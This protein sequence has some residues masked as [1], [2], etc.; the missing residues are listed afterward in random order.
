MSATSATRELDDIFDLTITV[1]GLEVRRIGALLREYVGPSEALLKRSFGEEALQGLSSAAAHRP[2]GSP[3]FLKRLAW[4]VILL[5]EY[6]QEI[7]A[8]RSLSEAQW[9]WVI[10]SERWPD[11]RRFMIRGGRERWLEL[12]HA[13]SRLS[14]RGDPRA[15]TTGGSSILKWLEEDLILAD[16]LRLHA[17]GFEKDAEGIFWLENM[18][19][20]AGL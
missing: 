15:S 3:R 8:S 5:A 11:F 19:L 18:L 17:E 13:V 7:R 9:A 14:Q 4:R 20:T 12:K 2:L 6:A 16:Y 10:I 1:P